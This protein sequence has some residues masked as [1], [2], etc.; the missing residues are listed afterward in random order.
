MGV[1]LVVLFFI[2]LALDWKFPLSCVVGL[3]AS[4]YVYDSL[5]FIPES[6]ILY[7]MFLSFAYGLIAWCVKASVIRWITYGFCC[8]FFAFPFIFLCALNKW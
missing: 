3:P 6:T 8:Q 7:G 2:G 5:G 1:V 4:A